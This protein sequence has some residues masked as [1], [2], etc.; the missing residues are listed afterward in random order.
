MTKEEKST[1]LLKGV[2][3]DE[4]Q[5]SKYS[6]VLKKYN[7]KKANLKYSLQQYKDDCST[8]NND[9]T[10]RNFKATKEGFKCTYNSKQSNMIFFSIPYEDGWSAFIDGKRVEK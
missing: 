9:L 5:I 2:L 4:S 7:V 1:L 10:T 6:D 8:L 3:L